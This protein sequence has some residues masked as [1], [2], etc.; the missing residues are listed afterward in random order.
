[1]MKR[2][3]P[4]RVI[5]AVIL[6]PLVAASI[7][8]GAVSWGS[9]APSAG[10]VA[11]S[12]TSLSTVNG[13][14]LYVL[15]DDTTIYIYDMDHA[16]ALVETIALPS[17]VVY[18]RGF[19]ADPVSRA[20]YIGYHGTGSGGWLLKLDLLTNQVIYNVALPLSVDSFAVTPDGKKIYMPDG[21]DQPNGIW[22]IMDAA[23]GAVTG[24]I[25]TGGHNPHNTIV[26]LSGKSVLMGNRLSNYLVMADTATNQIV[27]QIGPVQ[28]GVRPFTVNGAETLAFIETS[29]FIGFDVADLASG[30]I[31]WTV[32]TPGYSF[33]DG[34][35]LYAPAHGIS[36]SPNEREIYITDWPNSMVH[37]FDVTGLPAQ[38][39]TWLADIPVH[40]MNGYV[41]PCY[42]SNCMKEGWILHSRD[43]RFAYVA[44]AGDVIDTATR[45]TVA[46]L[47]PLANTR[48]M[49]E[50]DW[51]D[52]APISSTTRFGLGYVNAVDSDGDGCPDVNELS[53]TPRLGGDRDSL[54]PWDFF[55]TP[56]PVLR[57]GDPTG[58]RSK[59]VTLA[60]LIGVLYYVGTSAVSPNQVN[61]NGVVYGSDLNANGMPDGQ[62][63]DRTIPDSAKP[64]RS[65]P[66]S[67]AVTIG[68]VLVALRQ[69]GANCTVAP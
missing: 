55:D 62:E 18:V 54:N 67:G 56:E 66:P 11:A 34:T 5:A 69:V 36:L 35:S 42:G 26:T 25:D 20:L 51:A 38:Q 45:Q 1:M 43:G 52:G 19:A 53:T 4:S 6:G 44:D 65:G 68:D 41:T 31:L 13:H 32:P 48:K 46:Y 50:I 22:H 24:A 59:A 30:Q 2:R 63:Y 29:G 64:Y 8:A 15:P 17:N 3:C 21:D 60:D 61:G 23:T 57:P 12:A 49:L 28:N 7:S 33:G 16:H 40:S 37:V 9:P 27:R 10:D 14:Y 47:E 39:P 58:S